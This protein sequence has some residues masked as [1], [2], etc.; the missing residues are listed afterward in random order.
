MNT[1]PLPDEIERYVRAI[2]TRDEA[3]F[4]DAFTETAL[5]RDINREF[6]GIDAISEWARTDIFAVEVTLEVLDWSRED[7]LVRVLM[8]VEGTFDRT[9]LPDPLV[10]RHT[11]GTDGERI[12]YLH[13]ELADAS[14]S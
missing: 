4:R 14:K 7:D 8:R 9:G 3:A 10:M 11:F 2:N 1:K 5:V 6:R 13:C 12:R